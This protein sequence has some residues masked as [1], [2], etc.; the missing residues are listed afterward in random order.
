MS[1]APATASLPYQH[2]PPHQPL[3]AQETSQIQAGYPPNHTQTSESLSSPVEQPVIK[4]NT[5][6]REK[7]WDTA[8]GPLSVKL[9]FNPCLVFDFKPSDLMNFVTC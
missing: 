4:R 6:F 9:S 2:S 3:Y 8:F 7:Q 5:S 1:R